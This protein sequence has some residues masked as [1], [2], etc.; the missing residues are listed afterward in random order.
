MDIFMNLVIMFT[1]ISSLIKPSTLLEYINSC[2]CLFIVPPFLTHMP[3]LLIRAG[4]SCLVILYS[5]TTRYFFKLLL[6]EMIFSH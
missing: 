5:V 3:K 4:S 2:T 6:L 1:C